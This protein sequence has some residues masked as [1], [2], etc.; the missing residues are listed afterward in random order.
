[1]KKHTANYSRFVACVISEIDQWRR[2]EC[3]EIEQH[4]H[5][6]SQIYG[7][8]RAALFLLSTDE[9]QDFVQFIHEKG[10]SH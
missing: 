3:T 6:Q 5:V 10:F 7:I 9:Y 2:T 4:V 1:M 8:T